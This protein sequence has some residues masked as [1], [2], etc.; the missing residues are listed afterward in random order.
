VLSHGVGLPNWRTADLP[1][2]AHF[3]LGGRL[4]WQTALMLG[5]LDMV[6]SK[7]V[8]LLLV[9]SLVAC[10]VPQPEAGETGP[11]AA[12]RVELP[13]RPGIVQPVLFTAANAPVASVILFPGGDGILSGLGN[14]FLVR[15]SGQVAASGLNVAL[16]DAP[17]LHSM[18]QLLRSRG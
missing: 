2:M 14:N 9:T 11:L 7:L 18:G 12:V 4:K 6:S 17:G 15:V 5:G 1:L 3:P 13:S 8:T 16:A 10:S